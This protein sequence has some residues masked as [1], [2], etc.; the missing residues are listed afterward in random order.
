MNQNILKE[1]KHQADTLTIEEQLE[2]IAY[3]VEKARQ[4]QFQTQNRQ[5]WSDLSGLVTAPVFGEDA[6][7]FISR[8]RQNADEQSTQYLSCR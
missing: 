5:Q 7:S 8:T 4:A 6:Q 3:L 2:L 1:L